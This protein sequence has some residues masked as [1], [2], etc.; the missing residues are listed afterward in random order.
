MSLVNFD[1]SDI[2]KQCPQEDQERLR[3]NREHGQV[4]HL[5]VFETVHDPLLKSLQKVLRF[6]RPK[7]G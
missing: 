1:F 3:S 7:C 4:I 2:A 6:R 5:L